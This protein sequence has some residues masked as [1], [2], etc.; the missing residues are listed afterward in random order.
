MGPVIGSGGYL[1]KLGQV[2]VESHFAATGG[3][4]LASCVTIAGWMLCTD[5]TLLQAGAARSP[6]SAWSAPVRCVSRSA[7]RRAAEAEAVRSSWRPRG[8]NRATISRRRPKPPIPAPMPFASTAS[9]WINPRRDRGRSERA[10][11]SEEDVEEAETA[12]GRSEDPQEKS[13][14]THAVSRSAEPIPSLPIAAV[15]AVAAKAAEEAVAKVKNP[16]RP[17]AAVEQVREAVKIAT[18]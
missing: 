6:R 2:L 12:R 1:G 4:I 15:P 5:Y 7:R 18:R 11:D 3:L 14:A 10:A 16:E 9:T 8:R 17:Q 13:S